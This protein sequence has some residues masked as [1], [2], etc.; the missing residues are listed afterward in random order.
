[1]PKCFLKYS[2][3]MFRSNQTC[4]F[5]F[6]LEKE[7]F[8]TVGL[9]P[10]NEEIK[11]HMKIPIGI[12]ISPAKTG[13][14]KQ[15]DAKQ[16]QLLRCS[17]CSA[18]LSPFCHI[19]DGKWIC[20][21]CSQKNNYVENE[22]SKEQISNN[23]IQV[24]LS[25]TQ[26]YDEVICLYI[27]LD[28]EEAD[29]KRAK[30]AAI[31]FLRHIRKNCPVM[32]F[33]G[34]EGSPFALLVPPKQPTSY[35]LF[36]YNEKTK[37][38]EERSTGFSLP[39]KLEKSFDNEKPVAALV[40][41][42]SIDSFVGMDLAQFFFTQENVA[43]AERAIDRLVPAKDS[44]C[45][46]K[47]IELS[48]TISNALLGTPC[49]F[50]SF[51]NSIQKVPPILEAIKPLA[52]RLDYVV[53]YF[54]KQAN[55]TTKQLSGTVYIL[56]TENP[57]GQGA[58]IAQQK[59]VYQ[60]VTRCRAHNCATSWKALPN[61]YVD[62]NEQVLFS[63]ILTNDSHPFAVD[64]FPMPNQQ[65]IAFQVT[66][67]YICNDTDQ[68][69]NTS[70]I[71]RVLNISYDTSKVED[72][73]AKKINWNMVL[74]FWLHIV[75]GKPP[76]ESLSM[77]VRAAAAV[78]AKLGDKVP[79]DF[80]RG[81]CGLKQL[82]LFSEDNSLRY[83]AWQVLGQTEIDNINLIPKYIEE[84]NRQILLA[85]DGVQEKG[86][87]DGMPSNEARDYQ[88]KL[89]MYLPIKSNINEKLQKIDPEYKEILDKI[90]NSLK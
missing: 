35:K 4:S 40:K 39:S 85:A 2:K 54:T 37:E 76:R 15:I 83:I 3:N 75:Y 89:A 32:I 74:W 68:P 27:S 13:I 8:S 53:S 14:A 66:A 72:E 90:V 46:L 69:G 24:N 61:Q 41:F 36:V 55:E 33:I 77:I 22:I 64:I 19:E 56:S 29:L 48:G 42:A 11:K 79:E 12:S 25:K 44:K 73:I 30:M 63:P 62:V 88:Q 52:V 10:Q 86:T 70:F 51:V 7:M 1:M 78:I 6:F 21:I 16:E 60:L 65:S 28:F 59:T 49:R 81:V 57:G 71:F 43:S 20:S 87:V 17:H 84:N 31:G 58:H 5:H 23:N 9:L 45:V 50:I 47:S 80:I 38:N 82:W 18:Y 67:K 34:I 26:S